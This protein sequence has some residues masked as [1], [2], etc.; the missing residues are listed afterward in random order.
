MISKD[1]AL[2]CAT[3]GWRTGSRRATE[4]HRDGKIHA[5]ALHECPRQTQLRY[6]GVPATDEVAVRLNI[7]QQN[8]SAIHDAF[9]PLWAEQFAAR[10]DVDDVLIDDQQR[11]TEVAA[12]PFVAHPDLIVVYTDGTLAIGELKT[13]HKTV[14][15]AAQQG[16]PKRAHLDQCRFGGLL[17]E[18]HTGA[19]LRGYWIYYLDTEHPEANFEMVTRAWNDDEIAAADAAFQRAL[20][21]AADAPAPRWFGK[22]ESDAFAP[23]SPCISCEFKSGCLGKDAD[24]PVRAEAARELVDAGARFGEQVRKAQDDLMEFLRLKGIVEKPK[25]DKAHVTE[26]VEHLGLE[27]GA[28][29]LGGTVRQLKWREGYGKDDGP[30]CARML[31][32]LGVKDVPQTWVSG[33]YRIE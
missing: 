26:V 5:S 22:H 30:A 21:L 1:E 9:L 24:D 29:D 23:Y 11:S 20:A 10:P 32:E 33:H 3:E 8:G 13:T 16:E 7:R 14:V 6:Q 4:R 28:Y 15:Q 31:R 19:P 17:A 18:H 25:R 2:R 27:Q 12:G